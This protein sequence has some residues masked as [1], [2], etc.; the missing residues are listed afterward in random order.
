MLKSAKIAFITDIY[1]AR[2]FMKLKSI[3]IERSKNDAC[4]LCRNTVFQ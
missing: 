1:T 3:G 2:T 4:N